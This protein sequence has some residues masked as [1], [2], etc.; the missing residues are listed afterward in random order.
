[1]TPTAVTVRRAEPGDFDE[2][3]RLTVEAY[4]ADGQLEEDHGYGELL[5]DVATR[6]AH[7]EVL[8]AVDGGGGPLLGSVAFVLP[9]TR[10]AELSKL[11]EAEFRMLAV[12]PAAQRRGVARALVRACVER[13]TVL[14]CGSLVISTRDRN[15]AAF[16]LYDTF[17][18]VREPA[19]DWVPV[20]GVNLLGL[21]LKLPTT[22]T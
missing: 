19:L 8:V 11:G 18:F 6:A 21:R 14:G 13:A 16:A 17:G 7:S 9:G 10:Y 4:R 15:A 5:A 20:P 22:T 1:M 12:D 3:A 2:V